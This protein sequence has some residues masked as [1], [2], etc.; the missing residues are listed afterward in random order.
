MKRQVAGILPVALLA[1]MVLSPTVVAQDTAIAQAQPAE[2]A[3]PPKFETN[4]DMVSY[5]IGSQLGQNFRRNKIDIQI[6]LFLQGLKDGLAGGDLALTP[7]QM[8]E[9]MMKFQE[10]MRAAQAKVAEDNLA[11][12]NEFLE[13]NKAKEGVQSTE[14]GLQYQV[15]EEGAGAT[16]GTNDR[17]KVHYR[18]TLL[19]GTEFDSSYE[20]G[21]PAEFGVTDVIPGWTEALQ[22]MKEGAKWTLWIPPGLAYGPQGRPTIPPNS[23]LKFEVELL[24]VIAG[25]E[26]PA[27]MPQIQI[28]PP[29]GQ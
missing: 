27:T 16:P 15:I 20:R 22:M 10:E 6:D 24:E 12:A 25:S 2:V 13:A 11:E 29:S 14:S 21:E 23:L 5:S 17:V 7:E 4:M 9:A 26:Q 19:D 18:G 3:A 8:Q 28:Q 1:M